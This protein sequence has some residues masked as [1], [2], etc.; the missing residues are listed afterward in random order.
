M[1]SN[2]ST[3]DFLVVLHSVVTPTIFCVGFLSNTIW[4]VLLC[5]Q[6]FRYTVNS[7]TPMVMAL[8]LAVCDCCWVLFSG[9]GWLI[10]QFSTRSS[11]DLQVFRYILF[12]DAF[13]E[14]MSHL[15]VVSASIERFL[16][17]QT[18]FFYDKY[19][20]YTRLIKLII[21]C[22][23]YSFLFSV[24]RLMYDMDIYDKLTIYNFSKE[25]SNIR[26]LYDGWTLCELVMM[27]IILTVCNATVINC[28]KILR[29]RLISC[30]PRNLEG[31]LKQTDM[32]KG[33][34]ANFSYMLVA[35]TCV[36]AITSIPYQV[37][38][39]CNRAYIWQS[40]V[41]DYIASLMLR[42]TPM[43]NPL[44][45][46]FYQKSIRQK[47]SAKFSCFQKIHPIDIDE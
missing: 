22:S 36:L 16:A 40:R 44:V 42:S 37:R 17:I 2:D 21:I 5:R 35:I 14:R 18:P 30:C 46:I 33:I 24:I 32:V 43:I 8:A 7:K 13:F 4:I 47:I 3:S 25:A 6:L 20:S 23:I 11:K 41:A 29:E 10:W 27:L 26:V 39:I 45:Y 15:L 12:I 9:I 38:I 1:T 28:L 34:H 31:Y 19:N